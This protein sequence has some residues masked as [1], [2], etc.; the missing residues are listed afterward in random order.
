MG[1]VNV[2]RQ[3]RF[4]AAPVWISEHRQVWEAKRGLRH[5]YEKEYFSRILSQLPNGRTLEIGAGPGFF[6]EHYR[7]SVVTDITISPHVDVVAD[8]HHL[9]FA[10]QSFDA[11]MGID[12][13][14]HFA[15]PIGALSELSRV[16]VDDGRL[17]LVEP[18]PTPVSRL[19]YRYVHHEDCF[20]IREPFGNAFPPGKDP[21][22]GNAEIPA[23]YFGKLAACLPERCGLKVHRIELFGLFGY[24][25]TGGFTQI[26]FGDAA[27]RASIALDRVTPEFVRNVIALKAFIVADKSTS[28]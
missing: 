19:F 5:Y 23:T 6:A 18:W 9:P 13:L 1:D 12:V 11:V 4:G 27:T 25:A 17:L 26:Y 24:L 14:H 28:A 21:M 16:L 2:S 8:V 20:D 10:S 22:D 3:N 7:A 15:D